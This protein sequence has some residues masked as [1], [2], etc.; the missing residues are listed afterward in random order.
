[1]FLTFMYGMG[2]RVSPHESM[3]EEGRGQ[4]VSSKKPTVQ[5][6]AYN[7]PSINKWPHSK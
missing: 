4:L 6:L 3:W 5:Q 2:M 7:K 1:M